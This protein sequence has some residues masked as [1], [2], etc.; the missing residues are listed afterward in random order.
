MGELFGTDGIRGVANEHPMTPEMALKLGMAASYYFGRDSRHPKILIGKDTRLSCYMFENALASGICAMGADVLLCGPMPTPAVAY[1]TASMRVDAGVIISA[2]HNPYHD[3]GIKFVGPDGF[4][5]RDQIENEIESLVLSNELEKHRV[6]PSQIG[7]ARRIVDANGRYIVFL[8]NYFPKDLSLNGVKIVIDCANGAAYRVAPQVFSELGA[9]VTAIHASPNGMNINDHCG[10]TD[11]AAL[12]AKVRESGAALGIALDGD[13]DRVILVDE[14]G[15][16]VN[17]DEMLGICAMD[18]KQ[19]G[20]LHGN[21]FVATVMS[22]FGLEAAMRAQGIRVVPAPVGDRYVIEEMRKDGIILG[23]EQSGHIVFLDR[24]TTGD[25][26]LTALEV[27]AISIRSGKSLGRLKEFMRKF[28][29]TLVN[30]EVREKRPLDSMT[31]VGR[32]IKDVESK[33]NGKG[34]VYVRYSGTEPL[35]RVL[36]EGEDERLTRAFAH[37]IAIELEREIGVRSS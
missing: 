24:H 36:V 30:V 15:E 19:S 18:Y 27:L 31:T 14:Q 9:D 21:A 10:A 1:L 3:N 11:P 29:Q 35:A 17:G 20:R 33:L 12:S 8:K 28:A 23:G 13:G 37:Q 22:N 4:K 25:G 7:K 32:A 34:R 16:V 6:R 2:S 5:L 26:I